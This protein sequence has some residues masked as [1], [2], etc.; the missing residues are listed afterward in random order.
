MLLTVDIGN[1]STKFGVFDGST[2]VA[3]LSIPT[4][5]EATA[6]MLA[7][8]L[9]PRLSPNIDSAI[10][11]SVV[12]DAESAMLQCLADSYGID[13][14][15]VKND[16]S[17]GISILYEPLSAAGTDRLVNAF[18]AS[19][20]YGTPVIVC[21]FGTA[22]TIDVLNDERVLLGGIIA[23]G[24]GTMA[25]ALH[26]NTAKLPEVEISRP[27]TVIQKTTTDSIRSGVYFGFLSLAE[28]LI[29]RFKSEIGD[30]AKVIATGGS[31]ALIAE[32]TKSI[33]IVDNDLLLK[34]LQILNTRLGGK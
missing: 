13:P 12:P 25:K 20:L 18:A 29:E 26:L 7:K 17:F 15:L 34:G 5:R 8:V 3:K 2:L 32:D 33:D 31:A 6:D 22:L 10:V 14:T 1:T 27:E 24:M 23:P 11:C 30:G 28:G 4:V 16:A 9:L 19:D 21:S